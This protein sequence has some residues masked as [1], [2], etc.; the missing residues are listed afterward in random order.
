MSRPIR[1]V[2]FLV[3][4][5]V[6]AGDVLAQVRVAGVR[7]GLREGGGWNAGRHGSSGSDARRAYRER[8]R[9]AAREV[10]RLSAELRDL[11]ENNSELF[12]AREAVASARQRFEERRRSL[13]SQMAE[14]PDYLALRQQVFAK[15]DELR[16]AR[17]LLRPDERE[18][19]AI[20][21]QVLEHRKQLT[22]FETAVMDADEILVQARYDLQD[23]TAH[24]TDLRASIEEQIQTDPR[25][26]AARDRLRQA[27]ASR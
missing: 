11:L 8:I 26:Q 21:H 10:A 15:E 4:I 24:F 27:R 23:A 3:A 5:L 19:F 14:R 6:F 12:A 18:I 25:L 13:R 16:R 9:E 22:L 20:A 1:Q 2:V 7:G 17:S